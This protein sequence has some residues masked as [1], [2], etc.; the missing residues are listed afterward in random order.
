MNEKNNKKEEPQKKI[1]KT[2]SKKKQVGWFAQNKI[3]LAIVII[4][5]IILI[6]MHCYTSYQISLLT[7]SIE[8]SEQKLENLEQSLR[9]V[10]ENQ[11]QILTDINQI[12]EGLLSQSEV[13][14]STKTDQLTKTKAAIEKQ[15]NENETEASYEMPWV[16]TF[17]FVI[18]IL[19]ILLGYFLLKKLR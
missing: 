8:K 3:S 7:T 12:N 9:I 10:R 18:I 13:E 15:T 1:K 6:A 5:I 11:Q 16:L 19:C 17:I 4:I 14:S 2:K